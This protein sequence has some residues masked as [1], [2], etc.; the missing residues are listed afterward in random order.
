MHLGVGAY[1]ACVS[2]TVGDIDE[3]MGISSHW[4]LGDLPP[5][6]L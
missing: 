2:W 1:Q 5:L 4:C 3:A 6:G